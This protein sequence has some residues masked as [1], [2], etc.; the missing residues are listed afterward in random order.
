MV[1]LTDKQKYEI[2][3]LHEREYS[4]RDIAA[5]LE[6]NKSTVCLWIQRYKDQKNVERKEG[7]G[8]KRI[9]SEEEDELII[10]EVKKNNL[11]TTSEIENNIK[12]ILDVSQ[13]T[14]NRRLCEYGYD[15]KKPQKRPLLTVNQKYYRLKWAKEHKKTN[16]DNIIFSDETSIWKGVSNTKRWIN[17]NDNNDYDKVVK[18]P[19]KRQ[20]WGSI[21]KLF[22]SQ[23]YI[24]DGNMNAI[25]YLNILE[26]K[27][28][29]TC[30][31]NPK[32][33]FQDD[34]DPKHRSNLIKNWK[35][36]KQIKSLEWPSNSPDLN[37]VENVW[38]LL[39]KKISKI[40]TK[41]TEE[42]VEIIKQSWDN[43]KK[44]SID[45]IINSMPSRI[46]KIIANDGDLID[47]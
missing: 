27:L 46:D 21:S 7:S 35:N 15:Y 30:E 6:I 14:I 45:N 22:P 20:V 44:E 9:T 16:W 37:P 10:N 23:I 34:N 39:K 32:L 28:L 12:E 11:L 3:L 33:I 17:S 1:Q 4:I 5:E 13:S 19:L 41:T 24:F 2:I 47:Y 40:N 38:A 8:R 25:M 43:I 31:K 29:P 26:N 36:E 42:F 18:Y